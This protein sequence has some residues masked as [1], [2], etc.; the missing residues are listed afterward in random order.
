[1]CLSAKCNANSINATQCQMQ[2][3]AN[4]SKGI[5]MP[6]VPTQHNANSAKCNIM[7][8]GLMQHNANSAKRNIMPTVPVPNATYYLGYDHKQD[9]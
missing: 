9:L 4:S 2:Y 8:T 6:T 1:M 7:T 5:L 3:N